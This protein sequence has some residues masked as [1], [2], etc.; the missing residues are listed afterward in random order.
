MMFEVCEKQCNQC[1]FSNNKIVPD[2]RKKSLLKKIVREQGYFECHK[3]TIAGKNTCCKGFYD[4]LG[5]ESQM[6]RI[7]GRLNAIKFVE[8]ETL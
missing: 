2:S 6:I 3:A 4:K 7:A 1:L 8:V 5:M